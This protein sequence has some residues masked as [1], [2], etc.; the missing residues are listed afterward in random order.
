MR[1]INQ[2]ISYQDPQTGDSKHDFSWI[3]MA[4][5]PAWTL[6]QGLKNKG[7]EMNIDW[8]NPK[9]D[10]DKNLNPNV[11]SGFTSETSLATIT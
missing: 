4:I 8:S 11:P 7:L 6:S 1:S 2:N 5:F 10:M 3:L 9:V